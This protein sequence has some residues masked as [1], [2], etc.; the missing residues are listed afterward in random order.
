MSYSTR[1]KGFGKV[2]SL[3]VIYI[4]NYVKIRI[5]PQL[6]VQLSSMFN[7]F[8]HHRTGLIAVIYV[9]M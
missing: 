6:K 3:I 8:K 4:E 1:G 2:W 5:K 9:Q 7:L